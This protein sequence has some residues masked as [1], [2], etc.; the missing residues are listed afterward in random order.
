MRNRADMD[1]DILFAAEF[2][3]ELKKASIVVFNE[4]LSELSLSELRKVIN[5]LKEGKIV[6]CRKTLGY[7]AA[8]KD[9]DPG[10][11]LEVK[12]ILEF[13]KNF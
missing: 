7:A 6:V 9:L 10:E 12:K 3:K 4:R 11:E 8:T 2:L 13:F 1:M 5:F